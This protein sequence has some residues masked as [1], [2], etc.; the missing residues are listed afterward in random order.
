MFVGFRK[1]MSI[2]RFF[3]LMIKKKYSCSMSIKFIM[4]TLIKSLSHLSLLLPWLISFRGLL[5]G[6]ASQF[7][8]V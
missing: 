2:L 8:T 3:H 6:G 1:E 5:M 7:L 4:L